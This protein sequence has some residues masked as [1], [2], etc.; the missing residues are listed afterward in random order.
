MTFLH[1]FWT[2]TTDILDLKAGFPHAKFHLMSW[3]LSS[4][5][6]RK[7][8][9]HLSL[10]TDNFGKELLVD[11][12]HLP[13]TAVHLDLEGLDFGLPKSLWTPKKMYAYAQQKEPFLHIDG[14]VFIWKPLEESL[15][16]APLVV[17]NLGCNMGFY[18][19]VLQTVLADFS[20]IPDYIDKTLDTD[21]IAANAGVIGGNDFLFFR[22]YVQEAYNFLD[23]NKA[24]LGKVNPDYFSTFTEQYLFHAFARYR[25]LEVAQVVKENVNP[26]YFPELFRFTDLPNRCAYIHLMNGK[27]FTTFCE[28]LAQRLCIEY[29]EMYQKVLDTVKDLTPKTSIVVDKKIRN[30]SLF[31]RTKLVLES[32]VKIDIASENESLT[33]FIDRVDALIEELPENEAKNLIQEVASF[34][35]EKYEFL[36]YLPDNEALKSRFKAESIKVNHALSLPLEVL[37]MQ[38]IVLSPFA[39]F[40]ETEWNWAETNEFAMQKQGF[41]Y[42]DN[43]S[44][45]SAYYKVVLIVCTEQNTVREMLLDVVNILLFEE[46][47]KGCKIKTLIEHGYARLKNYLPDKTESQ[48]RQLLLDKITYFLYH[49][50]LC[51]SEFI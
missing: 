20:Y 44:R 4:M 10:Y 27:A 5:Q 48:I 8:Y 2:N 45:A 49:H 46:I 6:L 33:N 12:L 9:P 39:K 31:Y 41:D 43:L 18:K 35:F 34:E 37:F 14:D 51:L 50:V 23:R 22:E 1:S 16:S 11:R 26:T 28:D 32:W 30:E 24:H 47:G 29:P 25:G 7:F 3:V 36:N 21:I 15:L 38:E 19:E 42:L 17:Q 40:I 13:Y